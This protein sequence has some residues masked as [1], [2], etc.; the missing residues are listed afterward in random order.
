MT[1]RTAK[2]LT[3]ADIGKT[4]NITLRGKVLK[5][6]GSA[7][8]VQ[9]SV[10]GDIHS[11]CWWVHESATMEEYAPPQEV[12]DVFRWRSPTSGMQKE[13]KIL[14][15]HGK[16]AWVKILPD[17][18]NHIESYPLPRSFQFLRKEGV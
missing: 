17:D 16:Q 11:D 5:V 14:A 4:F 3:E 15:I 8:P 12:G 7:L 1:I 9:V 2:D 6:D 18:G 13:C 10:K